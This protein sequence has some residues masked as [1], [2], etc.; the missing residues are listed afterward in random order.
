MF[1]SAYQQQINQPI[2]D[3]QLTAFLRL[4]SDFDQNYYEIELPLKISKGSDNTIETVWPEQN[5]IDL[6]LNELYALKSQRDRESYSLSQLYPQSGP[7]MIDK[8]GIRIMGRPDLSSVKLM[9]IGV[10]NPRSSDGKPASVCIWADELRL[11]D[12]DRSSGW[13]ANAVVSAK[14]ADLGTVSGAFR[15]IGFGYGGVQS[16]ISE[17]ARGETNAYDVSANI[18]VDKLLPKQLGLKIPMFVSYENTTINPKY[19]PANPDTRIDAALLSYSTDSERQ[20]YLKKIQDRTERRSLNFTNVRR[21]KTNPQAASHIYDIENFSF[22]YAYSESKQTNFNLE[23]NTKRSIK[24]AVAWQYSPKFKGFEPFK[25]MK[26]FSSP[27]L[28]LIKDFN[29]NPVP[30]TL[31][32]RGELDRS[33]SKLVYR[34]STDPQAGTALPNYSKIFYFQS[35]LQ[36]PMEFIQSIDT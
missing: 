19:D 34:G 27:F 4:G 22:T 31:S 14:L 29:F 25:D 9:M 26:A 30:T 18:N 8:H 5:Q 6:D 28:Q 32:V 12:F 33:F 7:K 24:G 1:L 23:D 21:V 36:R 10:R 17:R 20:A 15:H 13:A 3:N 16:K 11:T 35:L 2:A